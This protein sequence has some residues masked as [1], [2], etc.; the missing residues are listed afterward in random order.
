MITRGQGERQEKPREIEREFGGRKK[1]LLKS[2]LTLLLSHSYHHLISCFIHGRLNN[3]TQHPQQFNK[4][5][6]SFITIHSN[7]LTFQH[8]PS[9]FHPFISQNE[10]YFTILHKFSHRYLHIISLISYIFDS[11]QWIDCFLNQNSS[12]SNWKD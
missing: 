11:S 9:N 1:S 10:W 7:L 5:N 2:F 3:T 12:E 4:T 6:L 8:H